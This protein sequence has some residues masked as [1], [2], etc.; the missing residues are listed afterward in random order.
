MDSQDTMALAE[1]M[2]QKD[3][4]TEE[5][6]T[7]ENLIIFFALKNYLTYLTNHN[8]TLERITKVT[9]MLNDRLPEVQTYLVD[10]MKGE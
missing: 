3:Y 5:F 6:M 9:M 2:E 8:S 4:T 10:K 7:N 1:V